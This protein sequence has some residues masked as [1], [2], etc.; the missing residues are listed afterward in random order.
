MALTVM[1]V[2]AAALL[3]AGM[4]ASIGVLIVAAVVALVVIGAANATRALQQLFS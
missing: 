2:L 4:A 3:G 1:T